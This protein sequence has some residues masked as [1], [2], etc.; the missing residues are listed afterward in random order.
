MDATE[1]DKLNEFV[2]ITGVEAE[3]EARFYL[4][5]SAWDLEKAV[6]L[7]YRNT[8][9]D[10]GTSAP[11]AAPAVAGGTSAND[12]A[13]I[14]TFS[15]DMAAA[16]D[17]DSDEDQP[18]Y[19]G[20]GQQ[21]LGPKKK[22]NNDGLIKT[23]FKSAKEHGGEEVDLEEE[24]KK[25]K[26]F[27]S[28]SGA[29]MRLGASDDPSVVVPAAAKAPEPK[30]FT[31]KF[32]K[33]GFSIDDGELRDL[34][35]PAN[36]EFLDSVRKGEIP[37]ELRREAQMRKLHINMEDKSNEEY[38]APAGKPKVKPFTGAGHMLGSPTVPI[39]SSASEQIRQAEAPAVVKPAVS[40]AANLDESSPTTNIQ[41][42]LPDGTRMQARFNQHHQLTDVRQFV[43]QARPEL[44]SSFSFLT[45]FPRKVLSDEQQ[46]LKDASLLNSQ[47][48][49]VSK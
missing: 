11:A 23:M 32:W 15:A 2:V 8:A 4:E 31:L 46:T 28:F 27:P 47:I 36:Q 12:R 26:E 5:S 34:H 43:E 48:I 33:N 19:A 41:I 35:D 7:F 10:E 3:Q 39:K 25:R 14:R 22:K 21:V 44:N 45:A 30:V 38:K 13:N 40:S 42:R 1:E 20:G 17:S 49:V 9:E 16:S 24:K 6:S 37:D 18:L 29:G